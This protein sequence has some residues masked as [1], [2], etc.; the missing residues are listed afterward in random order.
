MS[1]NNFQGFTTLDDIFSAKGIEVRTFLNKADVVSNNVLF[2]V[3]KVQVVDVK[4]SQFDIPTQWRLDVTVELE[5]GTTRGYWLTFSPN[6]TRDEYLKAMQEALDAMPED[7]RIIHA[8]KLEA[9]QLKKWD[10]PYY[11]IN[12]STEKCICMRQAK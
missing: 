10:N 8:C 9:I 3:T 11:T 5:D 1:I 4:D 6:E 2:C 12:R 7:N